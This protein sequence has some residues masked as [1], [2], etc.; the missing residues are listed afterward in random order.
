MQNGD[1]MQRL[2][3]ARTAVFSPMNFLIAL[4][5]SASS[6]RMQNGDAIQRL[7]EARTA[8]LQQVKARRWLQR[9]A[10]KRGAAKGAPTPESLG[11]YPPV[12]RSAQART[13]GPC[14]VFNWT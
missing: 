12:V 11:H 4:S 1:A 5:V 14:P 8:V 9:A 7:A 6:T 3:G 2:A 10:R 13:Y